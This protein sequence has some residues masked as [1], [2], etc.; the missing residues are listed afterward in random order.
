MT[1]ICIQSILSAA[2]VPG[3]YI[4]HSFCI[5]TADLVEWVTKQWS[6][7]SW[8][9]SKQLESLIGQLQHASKLS[10]VQ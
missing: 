7:K 4:R 3:Y 6:Q 8:C 10:C 2:G 5:G 9:K 1:D